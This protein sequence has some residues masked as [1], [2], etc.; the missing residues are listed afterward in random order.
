MTDAAALI[1]QRHVDLVQLAKLHQLANREAARAVG[2]RL[3]LNEELQRELWRF[4]SE[5]IGL[6]MAPAAIEALRPFAK[7]ARLLPS[8]DPA[9]IW[10]PADA[11]PVLFSLRLAG[12]PAD[13]VQLRAGDFRQAARLVAGL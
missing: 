8:S 9:V 13:F 3:H 5:L 11:D 2:D 10:P 1:A 7:V 12:G 4:R 6:A